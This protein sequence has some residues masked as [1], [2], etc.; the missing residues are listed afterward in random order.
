MENWYK[1]VFKKDKIVLH[2]T[3]GSHQPH[4][5]I[6]GWNA[7]KKKIGT[8]WVI[9][10]KANPPYKDEYDGKVV[11]YFNDDYWSHHLGIRETGYAITKASIGIELCNYGGLVK[12]SQGQF[13]QFL[14]YVGT[15]VPPDQVTECEFRGFKYYET[16]TDAQLESLKTLLLNI[17]SHHNIDLHEGLYKMLKNGNKA[18]EL[19]TSALSGKPGLWTHANYRRDKTDCSP[20]FK[21]IEMILSL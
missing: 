13:G 20:Q 18:F 17:S 8:A 3:A 21:L 9:G 2:H 5:V 1:Q 16:Y 6:D 12:N 7:N 15:L 14:T 19:Q 10:G 11:N 4:W